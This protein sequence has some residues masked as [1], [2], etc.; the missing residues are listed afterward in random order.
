MLPAETDVL[1]L[2]PEPW[3]EHHGIFQVN[4]VEPIGI[5]FG[6]PKGKAAAIVAAFPPNTAIV[7][8]LLRVLIFKAW[9]SGGAMQEEEGW[10]NIPV[11]IR[12][13]CYSNT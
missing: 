9:P 7:Y 10:Y 5:G 11:S 13:C 2:G 6:V 8:N 12:Y 3:K 4:V 1:C